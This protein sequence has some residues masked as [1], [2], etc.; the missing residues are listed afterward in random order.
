MNIARSAKGLGLGQDSAIETA[1]NSRA[2]TLTNTATA[3][4]I[5]KIS[6]AV[7]QMLQ[8]PSSGGGGTATDLTAVSTNI[9]PDTDITYD[10][11]STTHKFK[12]LYLDGS[13]LNLGNQTIKATA[14]GIEVPELKIGTGTNSVK[15][16]AG[17]DGKLTTTETDSSGNTSSP[18]AS[19]GGS[20]VTVSDTAPTSPS[21]GDQWFDSSS[22]TMFVYYADGSSSQWV[23]ATPAGQT[24]A[25]GS[26]GAGGA[27]GSSVTSYANLAAFPS[28]GNT[29]GDIG[30]ATDTKAV[31]MWDGVAWQ[32][33][34]MGPQIGPIFT[35]TPPATH[36][37]SNDGSTVTTITTSAA[38]ES[39]FPITY[40]WDAY[41]GSTLY[42]A[43]SL[44]PQ[45]T[46]ISE[47]NGVFSL[48]GSSTA[49]DAGSFVFRAK[50]SDG[51]LFTPAIVNVSLT[52]IS[53]GAFGTPSPFY[54]NTILNGRGAEF[55]YDGESTSNSIVTTTFTVPADCT[56]IRAIC[57]GAGGGAGD[58]SN[59]LG[60]QGGA[61][62]EAYITVTPGEVLNLGLG[63]GGFA[64]TNGAGYD[65]GDSYIRRA[66]AT[67]LLNAGGG[68]GGSTSGRNSA[69]SDL[70]DGGTG[71]GVTVLS[72]GSGGPG[73]ISS[74]ASV[75]KALPIA[76]AGQPA[77]ILSHG[78]GGGNWDNTNLADGAGIGF[79]GGG[80]RC[81]SS[82]NVGP[83]PGGTYGYNGGFSYGNGLLL[84]GGSAAGLGPA[85][86]SSPASSGSSTVNGGGGGGSFG[87]GG[88]DGYGGGSG[89]GG[90]VRIWYASSTGD[91]LWIDTATNYV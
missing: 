15:L 74:S 13:T 66:N 37:L 73:T 41:S 75:T 21:A 45:V 20:S 71:N 39:G 36:A 40:D 4:D 81:G 62:I 58:Q 24:G 19:G 2:N 59:V 52:F 51:V 64:D 23:P 16:T 31:Y 80:G 78:G 22:L 70:T 85:G 87:G 60:A 34:S 14:T 72:K 29:A 17:A 30:F 42:N 47:S 10:L 69:N 25:T 18:A 53:L 82:S 38:D 3:A 46:S 5:I 86:G 43:S 55:Y 32:R 68:K 57:I 89:A 33:M 63:Q 61:G 88:V 6:G 8:P 1:V 27:D 7:K 50:A 84:S 11:G 79:G 35:T 65:G 76:V 26:A 48:V 54:G 28:S 91:P 77:G 90:L 9:I 44:P 56:K 83:A 67:V 12:D 49:S